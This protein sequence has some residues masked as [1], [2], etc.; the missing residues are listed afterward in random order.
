MSID[1][2]MNE[3]GEK[4]AMRRRLLQAHQMVH[5]LKHN[6]RT[7]KIREHI[8]NILVNVFTWLSVIAGTITF[9][10]NES[11]SL[12]RVTNEPAQVLGITVTE[13]EYGYF[14]VV[15]I[16]LPLV[17]S[18]LIAVN[19]AFTPS[20]KYMA[21]YHSQL[22][23]ESEI[24]KVR[25]RTGDYSP[26]AAAA[27]AAAAAAETTEGEGMPKNDAKKDSKGVQGLSLFHLSM[28]RLYPS[29]FE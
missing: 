9:E 5:Q 20:S 6:A 22:Y 21:L 2:L 14:R 26:H 12:S 28:M 27:S 4:T 16:A 8:I 11:I 19:A 18:F 10:A 15:N 29:F 17:T 7:Q 25:T 13:S 3:V 1:V 24:Y 23:V